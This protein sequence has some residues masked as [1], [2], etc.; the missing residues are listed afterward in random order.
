MFIT[1]DNN[2][3]SVVTII[4]LHS[5]CR[6]LVEILNVAYKFCSWILRELVNF[7]V[8]YLIFQHKTDDKILQLLPMRAIEESFKEYIELVT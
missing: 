5:H 6:I 3:P 4:D 2:E 1:I 8:Q 7:M